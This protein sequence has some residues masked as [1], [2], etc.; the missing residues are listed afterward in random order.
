MNTTYIQVTLQVAVEDPAHCSGACDFAGAELCLLFGRSRMRDPK[1][2]L[3][4]RVPD[5]E[6]GEKLLSE[7]M[8]LRKD[9]LE[10]TGSGPRRKKRK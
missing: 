5:C 10:S 3:Y 9:A 7:A 2:G 1:K 6:Q 4:W 8:E